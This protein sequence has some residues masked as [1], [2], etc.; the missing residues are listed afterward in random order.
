MSKIEV[1]NVL[2]WDFQS[3]VFRG[4][5][6]LLEH[7]R[8][9]VWRAEYVEPLDALIEEAVAYFLSADPSS[10]AA[11]GY[12]DPFGPERR[13]RTP[14]E[15][16]DAEILDRI[17]QTGQQFEIAFVSEARWAEAF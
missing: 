3:D 4:E 6:R 16:L 9:S 13:L 17:E 14:Q 2:R 8:G 15:A 10:C 11:M 7:L 12:H 1:G 5:F